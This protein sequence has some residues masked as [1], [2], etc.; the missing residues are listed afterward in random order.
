MLCPLSSAY[1]YCAE[2]IFLK[3]IN[4]KYNCSFSPRHLYNAPI[5]FSSGIVENFFLLILKSFCTFRECK[6]SI[7]TYSENMQNPS[8]RI[9]Q[10][11]LSVDREYYEFWDA[12]CA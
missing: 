5:S 3:R 2:S 12:S 11:Y 9:G 7:L 10:K 6:E 4:R 1:T 8:W